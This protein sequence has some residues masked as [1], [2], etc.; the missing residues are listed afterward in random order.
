MPTKKGGETV[1]ILGQHGEFG[2]TGTGDAIHPVPKRK[3][4]IEENERLRIIL[5]DTKTGK[6]RELMGFFLP[7][8]LT[9][10]WEMG[11]HV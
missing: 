6:E 5:K 2:W 1:E 3:I 9:V 11:G 10:E 4:E 7:G 8:V